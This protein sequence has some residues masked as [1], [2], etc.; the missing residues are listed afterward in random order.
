MSLARLSVK[1]PV[2]ANLLMITIIVLG[3]LSFI[4][5]PRELMSEISLNWVFIITPYPGVSA[6]EIEKLISIPIEDEIQDVKGIESIASQSTEGHSF[7][8]VKFKEMSD[9]EFRTRFQ[10]L[11]AEV[12]KVKDLPEDALDTVV[13]SFTT[14]DMMPVISVHLH[15]TIPEKRLVTLAKELRDQLLDIPRISKVELQGVRDRQ[16]WIEADPVRLEG[17]GLST[18]QIR[19]AIAAHGVNI[20][21]GHVSF[22][23]Q[24]MIVRTV[25]EF[26]KSEDIKNVIV[27]STPIGQMVR[28]QDVATVRETFKDKETLSRLDE[29]PV[30]SMTITKQQ[31]G[32]SIDITDDVKRISKEFQKRYEKLVQVSFT[33]DSSETIE[34]IMS[35]LSRNAWAGFVVVFIVLLIVMGMRNAILAAMGI[36]ISFLACFIFMYRSGGS[37]DGNSLFGLVLVLGIIVDDAIIIVEN[38]YRHLQQGKSW[39]DAAIDGA[40][41][42]MTPV[43]SATATTI[44]AFLPLAL[45]PGIMGK[46]LRVIPITVCLALVASMVEAFV[47][48]PSHFADWPGKRVLKTKERPWLT[49]L[50]DAYERWLRIVVRWRYFFALVLPILLLLGAAAIIPLVGVDMFAGEEIATFQVRIKLPVGTNLDTT[51][52]VLEEFEKAARELPKGEVRAVHATAGLIM[53]DDDWIFKTHVAQLWLDLVPSYERHRT[54]D[55]IMADLRQRVLKISGPTSIEL[56]KVNTGPPVGKPVEVKLKGKYFAQ[57]EEVAEILKRDLNQIKGVT[58]VGDDFEKGKR[59]IRFQVDP[60]RAALYGLRVGQVGLAIR[61]AVDGVTADKMY[62]GD[63]EL[64]IVVRVD[65]AAIKRPEDFLR[66][67][68]QTPSGTNVTLGNVAGYEIQPSLSEIRRYKQQRAIT[69]FANIDKEVT[70]SVEVNQAIQKKFDNIVRQYPG[71]MLDFSGEF[72]EFKESF[73]GLIQLFAFGILLIYAI[74]ATQFRSYSQPLVILLTVPF[75]FVGATLGILISGNPFSLITL[76]GFVA[77]AGVAVNDAIVLITFVNNLKAQGTEAKEAVVRAGRLRLRPIILTSVT[78]IAGLVPM[79]IGLGGMSLTWAPLAN[80]ILWGL[81][82]GTM[83]TIFLIPAGYVIIVEDIVGRLFPKSKKIVSA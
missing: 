48:L 34:D 49:G 83:L 25:G 53:T 16:V 38:C 60:E 76:F 31:D 33:Q 30:V 46:F 12:D 11:R 45:L 50:Q 23:R 26:A 1:N 52:E 75:S 22:G 2:V 10:D 74:L 51:S 13:Q 44:A 18:E 40:R 32:N 19:L 17:Y 7:V 24:E 43:F 20:P 55:D 61:A 58:D 37:F 47:I 82:V 9:D 59:E 67:P 77:L 39:H 35:K 68:I 69:V 36:P 8:S 3:T 29:E 64:D 28:V 21:G 79:A 5:L 62:D 63:E 57:L 81:T 73:V 27:H 6:D 41:E 80:T 65:K 15:G 54:A 42:V 70:T 56:A 4:G 66:L 72:K 14:S 71:V 78:T